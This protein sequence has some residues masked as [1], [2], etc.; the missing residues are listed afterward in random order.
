MIRINVDSPIVLDEKDLKEKV[1]KAFKEEEISVT[2]TPIN[3]NPDKRR[4]IKKYNRR[5]R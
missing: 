1:K 3:E 5:R 4:K 2:H